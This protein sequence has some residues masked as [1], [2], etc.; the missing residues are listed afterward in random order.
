MMELACLNGHV[1]FA[2]QL[3]EHPNFHFQSLKGSQDLT[4]DEQADACFKE[5]ARRAIDTLVKRKDTVDIEWMLPL[6]VLGLAPE[7][8]DLGTDNRE[9][10]HDLEQPST[11]LRRRHQ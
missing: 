2:T 4:R 7:D 10:C 5:G 8:V 6:E 1:E 9:E 11:V 3:C